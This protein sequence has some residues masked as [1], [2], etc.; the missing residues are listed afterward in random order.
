[1]ALLIQQCAAAR[2][3]HVLQRSGLLYIT[4]QPNQ[5]CSWNEWLAWLL[6]QQCHAAARA[7]VPHAALIVYMILTAS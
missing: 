6:I 1:M 5:R 2:I 3:A 7:A 4:V